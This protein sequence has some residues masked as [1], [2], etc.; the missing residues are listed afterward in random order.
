MNIQRISLREKAIY[1]MISD[2]FWS[3][4]TFDRN[5]SIVF[6]IKL[7]GKRDCGNNFRAHQTDCLLRGVWLNFRINESGHLILPPW[8]FYRL[9]PSI[10]GQTAPLQMSLLHTDP[11][12]GRVCQSTWKSMSCLWKKIFKFNHPEFLLPPCYL[13]PLYP[14]HL[15][16]SCRGWT[17]AGRETFTRQVWLNASKEDFQENPRDLV[18]EAI[19]SRWNEILEK[20]ALYL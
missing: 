8:H 2:L 18:S 14:I 6:E 19:G 4:I 3:I 7:A 12:R 5:F 16:E 17:L 13:R 10:R 15:P 1:L 9:I 20:I 11:S